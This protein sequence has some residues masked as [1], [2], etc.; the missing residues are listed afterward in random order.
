MTNP[1]NAIGTPSAYNG[2]SGV[3]SFNNNLLMYE[4]RGV[5]TGWHCLPSSGMTVTIGGTGGRD[6]AI[7]EAPGLDFVTI[8]NR[9][10]NPVPI[11]IPAAPASN[12]RIDYIVAYVNNPATV[13]ASESPIYDN[14]EACGIV[15]A[16][17]TASSNPSGPSDATIRAAITADGGD[18]SQAYYA[19][20]AYVRIPAGT[21]TVTSGLITNADAPGIRRRLSTPFANIIYPV[22]SIYMSTSSTSPATLFAGTSWERIEGRFLLAAGST[23]A[24]GSTGGEATHTLTVAEMPNHDH[25]QVAEN[26]PQ[27]GTGP[28]VAENMD[29][30]VPTGVVNQGNTLANNKSTINTA[31]AGGGQAH[32]NMPPYLAVYVWK[33][34]A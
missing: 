10:N 11:T 24:A 7:A 31:P 4:G 9:T 17:G 14:P 16:S 34:T 33:R 19:V 32:N 22:G 20:L 25:N 2:R 21:T 5:L 3:D 26:E 29:G 13:T 30:D 1:D 18:G 15:V 28:L 6:V 23:Y 8:S 12:T 27:G